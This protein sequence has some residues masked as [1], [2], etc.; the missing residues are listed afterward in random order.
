MEVGQEHHSYIIHYDIDDSK[1]VQTLKE[2][3]VYMYTAPNCDRTTVKSHGHRS[4]IGVFHWPLRVGMP[5]DP[6]EGVRLCVRCGP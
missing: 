1:G 5:G 6:A 2:T 4:S 3:V